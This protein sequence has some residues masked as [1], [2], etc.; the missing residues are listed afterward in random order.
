MN[1][2]PISL[3]DAE[4]ISRSE[5]KAYLRVDTTDEDSLVDS[6]IAAARDHIEEMTGRALVRRHYR[7]SFDAFPSVVI[8]LP[9]S[10]LLG[11]TAVRYV[12]TDG[13]STI[14]APSSYQVGKNRKPGRVAPAYGLSWP[15]TRS[16]LDG[17]EIDFVAGYLSAEDVPEQLRI[18][19]RQ[20][21]AHWFENREPVVVGPSATQIPMGIDR[22]LR[23]YRVRALS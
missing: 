5:A 10:P 11:V 23:N 15:T 19:A 7:V 14:L 3:P 1:L 6:L 9:R 17:V 4:P 8:D 16:D 2:E 12:A 21:V 20:L 18:A 22:I 13:T